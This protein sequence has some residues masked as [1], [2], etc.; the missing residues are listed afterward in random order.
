MCTVVGSDDGGGEVAG[1]HQAGLS[2]G[3]GAWAGAEP[4]RCDSGRWPAGASGCAGWTRYHFVWVWVLGKDPSKAARVCKVCCHGG[5][6][7]GGRGAYAVAGSPCQRF[8]RQILVCLLALSGWSH[9]CR[10]MEFASCA[11]LMRHCDGPC[12]AVVISPLLASACCMSFPSAT[13]GKPD[14]RLL[15]LV[16]FARSAG[17][18]PFSAS[19]GQLSLA[20]W[21]W[22][23]GFWFGIPI[24][25]PGGAPFVGV[26]DWWV[27]L[28]G[29]FGSFGCVKL[30]A[31]P[32]FR[33]GACGSL[34]G[35]FRVGGCT[36][37]GGAPQSA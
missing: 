21:P 22:V 17:L 11:V 29:V 18:R 36:G 2:G 13:R 25:C 4:A 1:L 35:F 37:A 15:R 10:V 27:R 7:G 20:S 23:L 8:V 3:S 34:S 6:D 14:R 30:A 26:C 32:A 19:A 31:C 28:P 12:S 5:P 24:G 16:G 33:R 9:F